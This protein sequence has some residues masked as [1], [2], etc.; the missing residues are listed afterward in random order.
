[1][2]RGENM[3][4]AKEMTLRD[5]LYGSASF[6]GDK[7]A[8]E[9]K[10]GDNY[11][12]YSYS[13]LAGDASRLGVALSEKGLRGKNIMIIGENGYAWNVAYFAASCFCGTAV[14][15]SRSFC[16]QSVLDAAVACDVDGV[17][18]SD[19]SAESISLLPENIVKVPFSVLGVLIRSCKSREL[20]PLGSDSVAELAYTSGTEDTPKTV[21]LTHKNIC[22]SLSEIERMIPISKDDKLYSILPLDHIYERVCGM[23]YPLYRGAGVAYGEGLLHLSTNMRIVRPTALLCVPLVLE[24]IYGKIWANIEKKGIGEKVRRAIRLTAA[25]G[26][27]RTAVRREVF[28]E[29]HDSLGGRLS[30][31]IT[32]GAPANPETVYGL[33]EF[34]IRTFQGYG[35]TETAAVV[36]V[37]TKELHEYA[38][39]GLPVPDGLADIYNMHTD[40]VGEIRYKGENVM[41]GYYKDPELTAATLRDG[42]L[43]TGD[44][45]Y[46]D[47]RGF[48]HIVGRKSNMILTSR[49]RAVFP[50]ELET[51]LCRNP[52]IK[53]AL[54]AGEVN[55]K[56]ADYDIVAH[57]FPRVKNIRELYGENYTRAQL[58]GEIQKAI[59]AVNLQVEPHKHITRFVLHD[60]EFE[61]NEAGKIVRSA[62]ISN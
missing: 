35:L 6:F 7:I 50:E 11:V 25:A 33:R 53:E 42:W 1:M 31:I 19:S 17:I 38:S 37:N 10:H 4:L 29:I 45:G 56:R 18:Y 2:K 59:D 41:A 62:I 21:I 46:F 30:F 20:S 24:R 5:V 28:A 26:P 16:A 54:V 36:S 27:L 52:F 8:I 22:F 55:D 48:L 57:I 34:G 15:I 40:G 39:A 58:V 23:L 12:G 13:R 47:R 61:K 32:G 43:Y 60:S 14:P 3:P 44:M 49:R 9:E 51:L